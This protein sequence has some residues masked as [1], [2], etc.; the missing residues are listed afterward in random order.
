MSHIK[1]QTSYAEIVCKSRDLTRTLGKLDLSEEINVAGALEIS[2]EG[3]NV[4][5]WSVY[6]VVLAIH[7]LTNDENP[8]FRNFLR[9]VK[10]NI[11]TG[12]CTFKRKFKR[13]K[14]NNTLPNSGPNI[15]F[16]GFTEYLAVENFK[17][18]FEKMTNEGKYCPILL[19]VDPHKGGLAD[20]SNLDINSFEQKFIQSRSDSIGKVIR[21]KLA[22]IRELIASNELS[23]I[24]KFSLR[25]SL[26]VI[27]PLSGGSI[28]KYLSVAEWLLNHHRPSAI[29]S[30]DVADPRTRVFCLLANKLG[31]PVVQIQAGAINQE[32]IEWSFCNDDLMLCHGL[33]IKNELKKLDFDTRNVVCTGSAKFEGLAIRSA[34]QKMSLSNRFSFPDNKI[35]ILLLTSY[36]GLFDT[37]PKLKEQHEIYNNAYHDIIAEAILCDNIT[38]IIKPHPLENPKSHNHLAAKHNNIFVAESGENT[39]DLI[40]STDA[41]IS[42]GSTATFDAIILKK[43]VIVINYDKFALNP[44]FVGSSFCFLPKNR[45]E[46][47]TAFCHLNKGDL[48]SILS[49]CEVGREEFL[50]DV[51][52]FKSSPSDAITKA[53]GE[54]IEFKESQCGNTETEG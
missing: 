20:F 16:L 52:Y 26:A 24:H 8:R 19:T 12:Y 54:L 27:A 46:L 42:Y 35:T 7:C 1:S 23:S 25:K 33:K 13:K 44:L 36:T 4:S 37:S 50:V 43:A 48:D 45:S 49:V 32:C 3:A 9:L 30:I 2:L 18:I 6:E 38:L 28:Q 11:L 34:N 31:I 15:F 47:S 41:V 51:G 53:I 40:A 17:F 39:S 29:V 10:A 5:I 21:L 22:E 14:F